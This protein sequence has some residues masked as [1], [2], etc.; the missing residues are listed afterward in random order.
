MVVLPLKSGTLPSHAGTI[1][2]CSWV[3]LELSRPRVF[4]GII[5]LNFAT[6][7]ENISRE[8]DTIRENKGWITAIWFC[9]TSLQKHFAIL[10]ENKLVWK[11]NAYEIIREWLSQH[12]K[13]VCKNSRQQN[14]II[15]LKSLCSALYVCI[16]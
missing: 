8:M 13:V 5:F 10:I 9:Y 14:S 15:I 2:D 1:I 7:V 4:M 6:D 12:W 11:T 16:V 3:L